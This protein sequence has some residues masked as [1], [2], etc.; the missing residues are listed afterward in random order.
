MK[1]KIDRLKEGNNAITFE[2][3][4]I[5]SLEIKDYDIVSGSE[6][7]LSVIKS[8]GYIHITGSNRIKYKENCDRCGKEFKPTI[9]IEIDYV[10][11]LGNEK[12]GNSNHLE[13]IRPKENDGY[14]IFDKYYIET[15]YLSL[16]LKKICSYNCKGLCPQCGKD[17]NTGSCICNKKEEI[18]PRWEKLAEFAKKQKKQ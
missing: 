6:L 5:K 16:P 10:F 13:I 17:L 14:L 7:T 3:Y 15:F 11:H 1:I 18:D 8:D 12:K 2:Q 9:N 4:E